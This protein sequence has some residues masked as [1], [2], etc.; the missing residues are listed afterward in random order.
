M[1]IS[2]EANK[3]HFMDEIKLTTYR[4]FTTGFFYRKPTE[5]DQIYDN[6]TYVNGATY[7]GSV[8][9]FEGEYFH[10]LQK[11]KFSVGEHI[12]IM[13]PDGT[14]IDAEVLGIKNQFGEEVDSAP[15]A[16]EPIQVKLSS[17]PETGDILRR[18]E[19]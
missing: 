10:M 16:K 8:G 18:I 1:L 19:D 9:E 4:P 5:E 14:N 12:E 13:K 2:N 6:N 3:S 7:I 17:V 11:N 15:H